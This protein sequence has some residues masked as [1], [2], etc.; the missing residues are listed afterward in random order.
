MVM[1]DTLLNER[2]SGLGLRSQVTMH[3]QDMHWLGRSF[4]EYKE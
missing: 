3:W 4:A 2:I 1:Q